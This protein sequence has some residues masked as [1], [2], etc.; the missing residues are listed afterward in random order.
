MKWRAA[1]SDFIWLLTGA[2]KTK[3]TKQPSQQLATTAHRMT[4]ICD[5]STNGALDHAAIC[6]RNT[7][8]FERFLHKKEDVEKLAVEYGITEQHTYQIILQVSLGMRVVDERND[9][10]E[11]KQ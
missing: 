4:G 3:G 11:Q 1:L 10:L 6:A 9:N 2:G 8:I 5:S 7:E